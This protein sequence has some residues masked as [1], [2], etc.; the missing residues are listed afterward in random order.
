MAT[1]NKCASESFLDFREHKKPDPKLSS[2]SVA[3][4]DTGLVTE[5]IG[6]TKT[7]DAGDNR[8]LS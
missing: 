5:T 2:K 4:L 6:D 8:S 3:F 1:V 7:N